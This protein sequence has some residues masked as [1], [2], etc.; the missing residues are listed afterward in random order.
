MHEAY[1]GRGCLFCVVGGITPNIP[2]SQLHSIYL[3]LPIYKDFGKIE[4]SF[5]GGET[6]LRK[7]SLYGIQ[8]TCT[9]GINEKYQRIASK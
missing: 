5:V 2:S 1:H 4:K 3:S 8:Y 6:F 7:P 9:T